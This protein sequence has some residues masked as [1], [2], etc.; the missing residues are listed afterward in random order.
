MDSQDGS[1]ADNGAPSKVVIG[2]QEYSPEEAQSLIDKGRMTS[3]YEKKWNTSV[4]K[5]WPEF[6]RLSQEK[7]EWLKERENLTKQV[8]TF[9]KKQEAGTDT[10]IDRAKA[11]EAAK[12]L[13][14]V[15]DEDLDKSGYVKKEDLDKYLEER[16]KNKESVQKVLN[17]ADRLEKEIN[18]EDG[19]PKFVKKLVLA[20]ANTYGFDDL[21]KAYE[22]MHKENLDEWKKKQVEAKKNPALKTMKTSGQGKE[23]KEVR[24]DDNNFKALLREKLWGAEE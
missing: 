22:D 20:Y 3:E 19:R 16:D 11:R 10:A 23:P 14:F 12:K 2:D 24:P 17:E 7:S 18:G 5:V 8:E 9:N 4:D 6:G 21:N 1:G 13:G 15:L